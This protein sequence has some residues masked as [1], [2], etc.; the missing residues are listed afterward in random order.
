MRI[1]LKTSGLTQDVRLL[2]VYELGMKVAVSQTLPADAIVEVRSPRISRMARICW[3][4][5][6]AI[7]LTLADPLSP[8]EQAELSGMT[9]AY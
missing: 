3:A 1:I 9:W 4:D 6:G 2:D 8:D 7:G 5:R